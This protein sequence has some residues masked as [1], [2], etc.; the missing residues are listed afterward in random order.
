MRRCFFMASKYASAFQYHINI[1][2]FP[3]CF[4]WIAFLQNFNFI[5]VDDQVVQAERALTEAA[6][7]LPVELCARFETADS[8]SDD[9]RNTIIEVAKK[10]LA[11]I[12]ADV[13]RIKDAANAGTS[14]T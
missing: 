13:G 7:E 2:S 11:G 1:Q 4:A 14:Q 12:A 3:R 9:D 5:A 6:A 10:A 8:L